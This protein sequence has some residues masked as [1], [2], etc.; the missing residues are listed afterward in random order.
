MKKY[1]KKWQMSLVLVSLLTLSMSCE[2]ATTSELPDNS[3]DTEKYNYIS[4]AE[5]AM[6]EN[7][8]T[9]DVEGLPECIANYLDSL[10]AEPLSDV[11]IATLNFVREEELLAHDVYVALYD[12]YNVPVFNNISKSELMHTSMILALL[13]KYNLPD[14][15]ADHQAGVFNDEAI[16]N[17][18]DQLIEQGGLSLNDAIIVGETIED[19]DIADL[20]SHLEN[21]IDNEDVTAVFTQ[22]YKG[23]RNHMR[24]FYAHI[25]FRNLDYVPLFISQDLYDEIIG[26]E[27]EIGNGMCGCQ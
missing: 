4:P 12:K 25:N 1:I 27:W 20:I 8:D 10:P 9:I 13:Q 18:Y 16:Q 22:L 19:L 7:N 24:A 5:L 2:K 23:S 14:P 3:T 6:A 17:Y 11:E 21:D 15:A 26:S